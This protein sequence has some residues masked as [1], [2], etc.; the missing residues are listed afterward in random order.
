MGAT[1]SESMPWFDLLL[2]LTA[3][4][5][6][7]AHR[8]NMTKTCLV[9]SKKWPLPQNQIEQL[10]LGR[11]SQALDLNYS[12]VSR[13]HALIQRTKKGTFQISDLNSLNGVIVNDA[14]VTSKTRFPY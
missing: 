6:G 7:G 14:Q 13:A 12:S 2:R 4:P 5:S 11:T 9:I 1:Y 8:R 3:R 10:I